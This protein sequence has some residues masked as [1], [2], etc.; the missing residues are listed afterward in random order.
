ME[1]LTRYDM[2]QTWAHKVKRPDPFGI[3]EKVAPRTE[4]A[5]RTKSAIIV[6]SHQ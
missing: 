5:A 6:G 3:P 2:I 1:Y 4:E